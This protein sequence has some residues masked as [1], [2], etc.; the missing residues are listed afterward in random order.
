MISRKV[1]LILILSIF[2]VGISAVCAADDGQNSTSDA[3]EGEVKSVTLTAKKLSTTYDSGKQFKVKAVDASTK[4]PVPNFKL[5]L[6]VYTGKKYKTITKTTDSNGIAKYSAS[7]LNIGKHKIIIKVK[8]SKITSK[9][10]TSSI[11]IKKAKVTISAPKMTNKLK[12]SKKFKITV[13]NKESKKPMKGIKVL[14]KMFT[15]KKF[16][17]YSLKTNKNGVAGI[18]TKSLKKGLHKVTVKVKSNSKIKSASAK[19]TVKIVE[20]AKYMKIKV[21]GEVLTVKLENN[22]ATKALIEKLKKGDI[23]I[24]AKEYGGFEKVG[25]LGFS[26]PANDKYITTSSGDLVL[27]DGNQVSLF[28]NSNS[29]DYTRLGKVQNAKDLKKILGTGDVTLVLT[30]K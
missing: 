10:K 2:I 15:G 8:N 28:Y 14:V 6:K 20:G 5:S 13:K 21:N 27:Y 3:S 18:N 9:A 4:K 24:K 29:W 16:K 30:L 11:N 25:D 19:S 17:T 1:L 23:K 26:L 22:K 12:E 7:K